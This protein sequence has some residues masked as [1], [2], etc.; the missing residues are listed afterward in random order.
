MS[1]FFSA[2][3]P[4]AGGTEYYQYMSD[5]KRVVTYGANGLPTVFIYGA[6]GEKVATVNGGFYNN[7]YFAGRLIVRDAP[8]GFPLG[9]YFVFV[10]RL[11]SVGNFMPY[12]EKISATAD[13]TMKFAT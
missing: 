12:G 3:T 6:F 2:S 7:V 11:G 10:D 4:W 1:G 5:N 9:S 8:A 13:G